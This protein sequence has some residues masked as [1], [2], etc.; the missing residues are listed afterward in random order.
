VKWLLLSEWCLQ[1]E[2]KRY[3]IT[4]FG[5]AEGVLYEAWNGKQ[6]LATRLPSSEAAKAVIAQNDEKPENGR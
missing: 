6:M 4:K 2:C 1:S 3:T 5:T